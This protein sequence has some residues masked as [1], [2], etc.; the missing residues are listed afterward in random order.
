[1]ELK[2]LLICNEMKLL[3]KRSLTVIWR[4]GMYAPASNIERGIKVASRIKYEKWWFT[5][6]Y[7]KVL[8]LVFFYCMLYCAFNRS[9][10]ETIIIILNFN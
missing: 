2:I 3:N 7:F 10:S 8:I 1:M 6:V 4:I 5:V 9:V